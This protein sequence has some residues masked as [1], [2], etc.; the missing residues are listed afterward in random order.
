M[1]N[2]RAS[3]RRPIVCLVVDDL[4]LARDLLKRKLERVGFS[5]ITASTVLGAMAE[6]EKA[7]VDVVVADYRLAGHGTADGGDL[8]DAVGRKHP[9]V[10]RIIATADPLG[11]TLARE[12]GYLWYDKDLPLS[13]LVALILGAVPRA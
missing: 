9:G 4:Q 1:G 10:A 13:E 3:D 8:L 12:G 5:V 7:A 11:D 6:L 2:G